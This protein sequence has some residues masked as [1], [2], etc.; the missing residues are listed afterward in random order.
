MDFIDYYKVLGVPKNASAEAIKKSYRKLA[1]K[2]HPDLNPK[3]IEAE[4]KF[5]QINEAHEVLSDP[6]KRKKYDEYGKDWQYADEF[7]KAKRERSRGQGAYTY[8]D[9]SRDFSDFFEAMFGGHG[10]SG[11]QRAV[12]FRGADYNA[13]LQLQLTD[14]QTAQKQTLTINGKK[15]RIAIPVGIEDGQTIKIKGYGGP[16][17]S[18]GP[19]G[20]LYITFTIVNNTDYKRD[21]A[22]LYKTVRI[23]LTTAVLG[24]EVK[25]ETL[26]G[27]V[28]LHLK[29]G[30]KNG[31]RVK[32]KGKG[33]PKYKKETER[34]DLFL[35][36][37]VD[38]PQTL[39]QEQK[40]LFEALRKTNV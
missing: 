19:S 12:Q 36:Y 32:L 38:L 28:K 24:G 15:I 20:D 33:F 21:G 5:K 27:K 1:R 26:S 34:G 11:R 29:P 22:N 4:K 7:E 31:A 9:Q 39:T 37:D 10:F 3:N 17:T 16:G 6:K 13:E 14:V 40:R 30:T 2:Y 23:P 8:T 18:G 25:V 35:T